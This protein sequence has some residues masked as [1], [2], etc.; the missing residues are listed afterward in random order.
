VQD[1]LAQS[2]I[3]P[4]LFLYVGNVPSLW[5][6]LRTIDAHIFLGSAPTP[7]GK[8]NLEAAG[9][10]YPLLAYV[11]SD[12]PRYLYVGA[13]AQVGITWS[14]L[15]ELVLGL[16]QVMEQHAQ[17]SEQSRQFYVSNCSSDMF[18]QKL[19]QLCDVA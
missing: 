3:D 10:G 6:G 19:T 12:A 15:E 1:T 2:S 7:G 4:A 5:E 11:P 14:T 9:A 18:K 8:S 16:K 17:F 13:E